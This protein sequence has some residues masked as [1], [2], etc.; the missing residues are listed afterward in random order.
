MLGTIA[1]RPYA[2]SLVGNLVLLAKSKITEPPHEKKIINANLYRLHTYCYVT[3]TPATAFFLKMPQF[4]S[5]SRSEAPL[6]L[7]QRTTILAFSRLE[8]FA[9]PSTKIERRRLRACT[10]D[11]EQDL[12]SLHSGHQKKIHQARCLLCC[13]LV[14]RRLHS[15]LLSFALICSAF[16][17]W[18]RQQH[19]EL[20]L[21]IPSLL[22]KERHVRSHVI[23]RNQ[24]SRSQLL[25]SVT[26][27]VIIGGYVPL[28][29]VET[30]GE[31]TLEAEYYSPLPLAWHFAF[32]KSP[33]PCFSP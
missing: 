31:A 7:N 14:L 22:Q 29:S 5:E 18:L 27:P 25:A 28:V 30:D 1:N 9:F 13:S 2:V 26:W 16:L 20:L 32:K 23:R 24:A 19:G 11:G 12:T 21:F 6:F 4:R 15:A 8:P 3:V 17:A 33:F 10:I